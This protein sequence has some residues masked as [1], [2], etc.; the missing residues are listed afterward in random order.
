MTPCN[1]LCLFL[2]TFFP[3]TCHH[4]FFIFFACFLFTRV[5]FAC[6]ILFH[7]SFFYWYGFFSDLRC[8]SRQFF[9]FGVRTFYFLHISF[10]WNAR[11]KHKHTSLYMCL[12]HYIR[13]VLLYTCFVHTKSLFLSLCVFIPCMRGRVALQ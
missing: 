11:T 4:I 5:E 1:F 7:S 2:H 13:L 10:L 3:Y 9:L 12:V 8:F 6:F